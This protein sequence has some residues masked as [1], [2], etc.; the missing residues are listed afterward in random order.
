MLKKF[1]EGREMKEKIKVKASKSNVEE[2]GTEE[3]IGERMELQDKGKR[4]KRK[5]ALS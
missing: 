3:E 1:E 2:G 5:T 4:I